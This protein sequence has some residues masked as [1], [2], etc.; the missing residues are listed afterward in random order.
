MASFAGA[1]TSA[2][3]SI[4]R[5]LVASDNCTDGGRLSSWSLEVSALAELGEDTLGRLAGNGDRGC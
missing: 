5:P 2:P 3:A 4:P 1:D